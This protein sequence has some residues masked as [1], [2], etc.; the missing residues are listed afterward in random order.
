[1]R[2]SG[3]KAILAVL[4]VSLAVLIGTGGPGCSSDD[5]E[6]GGE[7][8]GCVICPNPDCHIPHESFASCNFPASR[9]ENTG[10]DALT[11][12]GSVVLGAACLGGE[13]GAQCGFIPA[14]EKLTGLE[15]ANF[16]Q[17]YFTAASAVGGLVPYQR[18]DTSARVNPDAVR[19]YVLLGGNDVIQYFLTHLDQAPLPEDGCLLKQPVIQA[20]QKTL[21]DVRLVVERYRVHHGIPE[22]VV[23]SQPPVGSRPTHATPA[24]CTRSRSAATAPSA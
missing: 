19:A 16:G 6:N 2:V 12:G 23:G 10:K 7:D 13:G 17:Q 21:G 15:I 14:L 4:A 11:I 8:T 9:D 18:V 24:V 20:M 22:V 5:S 3:K 1:M